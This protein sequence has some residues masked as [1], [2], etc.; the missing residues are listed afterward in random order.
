MKRTMKSMKRIA[1]LLAVVM[2][3]GSVRA[4]TYYMKSNYSNER[5]AA[6][7]SM[8]AAWDDGSGNNPAYAPVSADA[9]GTEFC[10]NNGYTNRTISTTR[11]LYGTIQVGDETSEGVIFNKLYNGVFTTFVDGIVLKKGS[12]QAVA[13]GDNN[14]DERACIAGRVVI[15]SSEN[16]PFVFKRN[17]NRSGLGFWITADIDGGVGTGFEFQGSGRRNSVMTLAGDNSGYLGQIKVSGT[18]TSGYTD[19]TLIV[20]GSATALGGAPVSAKQDAVLFSFQNSA[21]LV[22]TNLAENAVVGSANRGIEASFTGDKTRDAFYLDVASDITLASPLAGDAPIKKT[23]AGMLTLTG[24]YVSSGALSVE[25]GAGGVVLASE[26]AISAVK[27]AD[28]DFSI[29]SPSAAAFTAQGVAFNGGRVEIV[30]SAGNAGTCQMDG[31][32]TIGATPITLALVTEDGI[33]GISE[34]KM[35]TV[36][37]SVKVVTADDFAFDGTSLPFGLPR[38]CIDIRDEGGSVQGVYLVR[39][40]PV[41]F[42]DNTDIDA[43]NSDTTFDAAVWSDGDKVTAGNDYAITNGASI[44]TTATFVGESLTLGDGA[45]LMLKQVVQTIGDLVAFPDA[46][47]INGK[48]S[49]YAELRGNLRV[50]GTWADPVFIGDSGKN[51]TILASKLSGDGVLKFGKSQGS[52]LKTSVTNDNSEFTGSMEVVSDSDGSMTFTVGSATSLGGDLAS[53]NY[54]ALKIGSNVTLVPSK[55]M[56]LS[57]ANRGILVAGD[58]KIDV[59][60]GITLTVAEPIAYNGS[61]TKIGAGTLVL[62]GDACFENAGGDGVTAEPTVGKNILVLSNG[63]VEATSASSLSNLVV[64]AGEGTL[65]LNMALGERGVE[66][67]GFDVSESGLK[68]VAAMQQG[69]QDVC[70]FTVP[71]TDA[72]VLVGNVSAFG[73]SGGRRSRLKVKA[74]SNGDGTV[75]FCGHK[76]GMMI[77]FQ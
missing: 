58:A 52:D 39:R 69:R 28:E 54:R 15:A 7:W 38:F 59:P 10:I 43:T 64:K 47:I 18:Y 68:V 3:V 51:G 35:M 71:E 76:P 12:Y 62:S 57:A 44:R 1:S 53:Y 67:V 46:T 2:A 11:T 17:D 33:Y 27:R 50:C 70:L 21:R 32:C 29:R 20:D 14:P 73:V 41:V 60:D 66:C 49:G 74:V 48:S 42:R 56:T 63:V 6:A 40:H 5:T 75:S 37:E 25:E 26:S 4:T 19:T 34:V 65:S 8:T 13:S 72:A 31:D 30:V 36:P 16:T 61:L 45:T 23:G 77:V 24:A 55:T 9:T 22:L